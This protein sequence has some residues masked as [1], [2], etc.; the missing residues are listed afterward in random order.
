[1]DEVILW[2]E[3]KELPLRFIFRL[4]THSDYF[5]N[6]GVVW[7]RLNLISLEMLRAGLRVLSKNY[8]KY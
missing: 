4:P 2:R 1:V 8:I 7:G 6:L 3:N 5:C